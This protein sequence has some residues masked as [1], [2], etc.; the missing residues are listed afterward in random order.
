MGKVE[1]PSSRS[2]YAANMACAEEI[3]AVCEAHEYFAD[4]LMI[5]LIFNEFWFFWHA[6]VAKAVASEGHKSYV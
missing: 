3:S 1:E 6:Q 5:W 2:Q 4:V